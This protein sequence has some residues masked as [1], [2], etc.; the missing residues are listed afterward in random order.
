MVTTATTTENTRINTG[1]Q[2]LSEYMSEYRVDTQ[3]SV[4]TG[5][6]ELEES[7]LLGCVDDEGAARG[8]S[9]NAC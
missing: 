2:L 8:A 7:M 1:I 5:H 6:C 4:N 3:G 9:P